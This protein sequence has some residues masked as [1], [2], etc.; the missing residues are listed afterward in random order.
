MIGGREAED[1]VQ[2]LLRAGVHPRVSL[3]QAA[4]LTPP[5]VCRLCCDTGCRT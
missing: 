1:L 4:T 2:E 3:A 5:G